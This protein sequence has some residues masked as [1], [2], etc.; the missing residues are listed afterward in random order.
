MVDSPLLAAV[1][2]DLFSFGCVG[3]GGSGVGRGGGS[4]V[5]VVVRG[6]G[7]GGGGIRGDCDGT[8]SGSGEPAAAVAAA[9][10]SASVSVV[11]EAEEG[12]DGARH[13]PLSFPASRDGRG[14]DRYRQA[15]AACVARRRAG[16]GAQVR[17]GAVAVIRSAIVNP[18]VG[19]AILEGG[20]PSGTALSPPWVA[21]G[22]DDAHANADV[23]RAEY[24]RDGA[25][26]WRGD[27]EAAASTSALWG[28][29]GVHSA[30][31]AADASGVG[32][33]AA[34]AAAA[35]NGSSHPKERSPETVAIF[36]DLVRVLPDPTPESPLLLPLPPPPPPPGVNGETV[37]V[38]SPRQMSC[39]GEQKEG[40][41]WRRG[42][43]EKKGEGEEGEKEEEGRGWQ[44]ADRDR[45]G[46]RS[47]YRP[48]SKVFEDSEFDSVGLRDD[49]AIPLERPPVVGGEIAGGISGKGGGGGTASPGP[50]R[51]LP[52]FR[53]RGGE[54]G[55]GGGTV[56][57]GERRRRGGGAD[58][59]SFR[60]DGDS[61][62]RSSRSSCGTHCSTRG[63]ERNARFEQVGGVRRS[64]L[65]TT[66]GG[67]SAAICC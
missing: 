43:K 1:A 64:L 4:D 28:E 32:S 42:G 12:D 45:D 26:W 34:L 18:A 36:D 19:G 54:G 55:G 5:G 47:R 22:R 23:D 44:D 7:D 50:D 40:R 10:L 6:V 39:A 9:E 65:T 3:G 29:S 46:N 14:R 66:G 60:A 17:L 48:G 51:K 62:C 24:A 25:G 38:T 57:G 37:V 59:A 15:L 52:G 33:G 31:T 16:E 20:G 67:W 2:A 53:E 35:V 61:A 27:G 30:S 11:A 49:G 56:G 58:S 63:R 8:G 21:G 13:R 41:R